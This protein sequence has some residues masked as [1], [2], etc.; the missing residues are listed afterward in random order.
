MAA[1]R[2]SAGPAER[3]SI[4]RARAILG[5]EAHGLSDAEVLQACRHAEVIASVIVEM[6][7]ASHTPERPM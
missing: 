3:M 6:F 7:L 5:R 4:E 1:A 2:Q